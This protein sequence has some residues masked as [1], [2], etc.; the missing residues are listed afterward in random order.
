MPQRRDVVAAGA[1]VFRPGRE[2][3]L[4]HRPRYDDWSFPKGKLDPGELRRGGRRPRGGRG[5]RSPRPARPAPRPTSATRSP[6]ATK[7]VHYWVGWPV[8]DDDVSG[9]LVN[10]EIDEVVLAAVRRGD[11]AADL[12][13]GPGDARRGPA[14]CARRPVPSWCCG[15]PRRA[16]RRQLDGGP[17]RSGRCW[18]RGHD[19]AQRLVALLA[20]YDATRVVS[21][22]SV[23]CVRH[24]PALRRL[25]RLEAGGAGRAHRGG[26]H[27]GVGRRGR[28]RARWPART[29]PSCARTGRCCRRSGTRSAYPTRS[30][31]PAGCWSS[32]TARA[33]SSP[34]SSTRVPER[35]AKRPVHVMAVSRSAQSVAN[36]PDLVHRPFTDDRRVRSLRLPTFAVSDKTH[37]PSG[38][39]SEA[40]FRRAGRSCPPSR[41]SRSY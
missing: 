20:V 16:S 27:R 26:R 38:D 37:R 2:V 18:R 28:R 33:G 11:G 10:D 36:P 32:T 19:Q 6:A 31:S 1:V 9:Y 41:P 24:R 17:T 29:A 30:W 5:D 22:S 21:S 35:S 34:R 39:R 3:L 23:R 8:G 14:A 15:T 13:P 40:H 25:D 12:R 7:T 4:V